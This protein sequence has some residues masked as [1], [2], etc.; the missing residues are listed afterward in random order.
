MNMNSNKVRQ[1]M[2]VKN[3]PTI[4]ITS[5]LLAIAGLSVALGAF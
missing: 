5:T 2:I 3:M 4:L 1:G